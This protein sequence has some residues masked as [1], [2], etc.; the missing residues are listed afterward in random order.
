M[1]SLVVVTII[2]VLLALLLPSQANA[3]NYYVATN[4]SD[5]GAGTLASPY[6]TIQEAANVAQAGDNVY[7]RG[8]TYRETVTVA[9]SGT[10]S[11]PITFQPYNNEQATVSGLD[12]VGSS[13]SP[14]SGSIYQTTVA[15]GGA[16]QLFVGGQMMTEARFPNAGYN[17]PLDAATYTIT[18]ASG[19]QSPMTVTDSQNLT[20]TPNWTNANLNV[21]M[22]NVSSWYN[23]ISVLSRQI[24]SQ[25]GNTLSFTPGSEESAGILPQANN[26]A[27]YITGSL[28]AL[29]AEREW[30]YNS[31]TSTLYLRAPGSVNPG[32]LTVEARKR[33]CGFDLGSQSYIQVKGLSLK[34][35]SVNIA[36]SHNLIDNC[37]ILYPTPYTAP[38]S[39]PGANGVLIT[40]TNNTIS[41]SEVAYSWGDGITIR[42]TNNTVS[43]SVI[44]DVGW[45][46]NDTAAVNTSLSGGYDTISGNTVYNC[47]RHGI[48]LTLY[49]ETGSPLPNTVAMHNDVSRF[50]RLTGDVGG[51][52]AADTQCPNNTVA[53]N[54]IDSSGSIGISGGVYLDDFTSGVTAHHNLVTNCTVGIYAKD[55]PHNIYN[56]TL[57]NNTYAMESDS[58]MNGVQ[59][60]NNLSNNNGFVGNTQTTNRYQTA[61]QFTNSAAGDYTPTA[62]SPGT[63]QGATYKRAVDYGTPISGITDGY[64]GAA[65]DAGAF[66][67]GV[68]AWTAGAN[69]KT[70]TA[71][72][73]A[74]AP[75][76][77]AAYVAQN[78]TRVT[79]GS[80]TVGNT[81][82]TS[83]NNRS[84]LNFNLSG[85]VSTTIQSAVL[86]IYEN[87][88][89]TSAA[90]SVTLN[91]VTSA[92]TN[93]NV[94][95]NQSVDTASPITG[96]Y[97][98]S[99]LDL[100]TDIDITSWV[101]GWLS[102]PFTNYGLRLSGT[103]NVV[104]TAKYFDGFYGVT[105]PQLV[106]TM[107]EP[108]DANL[109]GKVDVSDLAILAANYRKQ[110]TGGWTQADFNNDG[111][112]D[113]KDLAI[114]AANYR[115]GV[116]SDVVPAYDGSD[117]GAMELLSRAGVTGAPEPCTLIML[118]VALIGALAYTWRKGNK[119]EEH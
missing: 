60:V 97:D 37:Q 53:Y 29:D 73:Q 40:G 20:G 94:S 10:S 80:L 88:L 114:L 61:N 36:G 102:N 7:V 95:Y 46:G 109:D 91:R 79:T 84:F 99:N 39:W 57:W 72:N 63:N 34:A 1:K 8:G 103:E 4:G 3:A 107:P 98:P 14:Y 6:K 68:A 45:A 100:Y 74:S 27:Y 90:G 42:N 48:A 81:T 13:W 35:A 32:T 101:Q 115:Y 104:G 12:V 89:P 70:W 85:I 71:G 116:S 33:T 77:A 15:S 69:F 64:T 113:V 24:T 76:A 66:E 18:G 82:S 86:R 108:G 2:G 47:G 41:N 30:Y 87:T 31:G 21:K 25:S 51:I 92:W 17:N 111:V 5:T 11:A 26:S 83:A 19:Y 106:I 59:T 75:L 117:A 56:N 78:G 110:V 9:H 58:Y 62:N 16:S 119:T 105:T 112:V 44:H 96:F 93:A 55:G 22:S 28:N 23:P 118:A 67:R 49:A 50:G 38:T 52:V 43:N 54:R 65:P